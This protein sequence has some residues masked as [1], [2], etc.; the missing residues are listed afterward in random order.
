MSRDDT[1]KNFIKNMNANLDHANFDRNACLTQIFDLE[2]KFKKTLLSTAKGKRLFR[3][4][5]DYVDSKECS[6]L[7][8][9]VFYRDRAATYYKS[10]VPLIKSRNNKASDFLLNYQFTIWVMAQSDAPARKKLSS[11]HQEIGFLRKKI[12]EQ[13]MPL[14]INRSRLY[15]VKARKINF[16]YLDLVSFATNGFMTAID[17]Y[18]PPAADL[19]KSV[20][21]GWMT[22]ELI[23]NCNVTTVKLNKVDKRVLYRAN[24]AK[25]RL[26]MEDNDDVLRF[27]QE[28]FPE[29]NKDVLKEIMACNAAPSDISFIKDHGATEMESGIIENNSLVKIKEVL[30]KLSFIESKLLKLKGGDYFV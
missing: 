5:L 26:G 3:K 7:S 25:N 12:T 23:T 15:Q 10:I 11:I 6:I 29:V 22:L 28:S 17:K 18:T 14:I 20:A 19:F 21:I 8:G 2:K 16:D 24:I 4:F 9:S 1:Y 13:D 30:N 27:V